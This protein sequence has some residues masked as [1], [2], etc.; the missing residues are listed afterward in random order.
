MRASTP[1]IV[2]FTSNHG[3][4][5]TIVLTSVLGTGLETVTE[6]RFSGSGVRAQILSPPGVDR[7][8]V[9]ISIAADATPGP[10][11]ILLP[12][13]QSSGSESSGV[14]FYVLARSSHASASG[15]GSHLI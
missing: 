15:I 11:L 2:C 10:R 13:T 14:L 8:D 4:P 3:I 12:A 9:A 1:R 5:G 7:I 6:V